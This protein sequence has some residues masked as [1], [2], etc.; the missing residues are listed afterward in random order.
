MKP[1]LIKSAIV[2]S[3]ITAIAVSGAAYY[4]MPRLSSNHSLA[5]ALDQPQA[6]VMLTPAV[7]NKTA[8]PYYAASPYP[9]Q[10]VYRNQVRR[11]T[12]SQPVYRGAARDSYGEP[13][14]KKDRSTAKSV[15]IVGASAGTGAAI[16]ALAG[17]GKGAAIGA[18][19]GGASGFIYDR[20][21]AHKP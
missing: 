21:T 7:H 20:L 19:A 18:L 3:L 9:P 11:P 5:N 2:T 8:Q 1:G 12:Y 4:I 10:F 13:I 6:E 16:G 15:M 14:V 17:G